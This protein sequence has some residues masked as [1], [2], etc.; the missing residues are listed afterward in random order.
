VVTVV[1]GGLALCCYLDIQNLF[2][3]GLGFVAILGETANDIAIFVCH[4]A[5]GME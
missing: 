3:S 4:M 5:H 2:D 1:A